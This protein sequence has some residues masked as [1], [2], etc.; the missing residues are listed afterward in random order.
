VTQSRAPDVNLRDADVYATAGLR[1]GY[2]RRRL[3]VYA[4]AWAGA[5]IG[6]HPFLSFLLPIKIGLIQGRFDPVLLSVAV[7]V[8]GLTAAAAN[9][10]WGAASDRA[11]RR[12][13]SR[14]DWIAGGLVATAFAYGLLALARSGAALLAATIMFQ[15]SLNLILAPLAA[16][17]AEEVPA[18][19]K[20][21]LGGVLSIGAPAGAAVSVATMVP[22][23]HVNQGLLIIVLLMSAAMLPLLTTYPND[24]RGVAHV[25]LALPRPDGPDLRTRDF[26]L[27]CLV[28]M[29]LQVAS[30]TVFFFLLYYFSATVADV[31]PLAIAELTFGAAIIALPTALVIGR[32]SDR[33]GIHRSILFVTIMLM[34]AGLAIM[35]AQAHWLYA[36]LGY[37]LFASAGATCLALHT[38]LAMLQ[39]PPRLG[40]GAALGVLNLSNT[41]PS[42]LVAALASSIVPLHGYRMICWVLAALVLSS[43]LLLGLMG[44]VK[45]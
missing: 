5:T 23:L 30:K 41:I 6:Y 8:S 22:G 25:D 11:V 2:S 44:D 19:D 29:L 14:R 33:W 26:T 43:G 35:A 3:L 39:L 4:I 31:S 15:L 7:M 12:G 45:D 27:L 34:S 20:G 42:V 28:R 32:I 18:R 10:C 40:S 24:C 37:V 21:L 38:G 9:L 36:I 16:L 17:L 1:E 13:G